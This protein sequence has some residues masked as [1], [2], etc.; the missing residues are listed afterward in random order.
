LH[1]VLVTGTGNYLYKFLAALLLTPVIYLIHSWIER[2][3][4]NDLARKMKNAAMG[5]PEAP[6]VNLP[7]AG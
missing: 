1:Q 5:K 4:G 3:L 7:A 6:G 2:Y